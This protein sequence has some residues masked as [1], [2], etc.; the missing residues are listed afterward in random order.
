LV[1]HHPPLV[2]IGRSER[3]WNHHRYSLKAKLDLFAS[4]DL[5]GVCVWVIDGSGE[6]PETFALLKDYLE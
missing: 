2:P 6:P 3:R 4:E 5:G 1:G